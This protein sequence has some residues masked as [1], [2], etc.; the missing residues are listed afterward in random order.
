MKTG[1]EHRFAKDKDGNRVDA[2]KFDPLERRTRKCYCLSCGEVVHPVLGEKRRKHFRHEA[3]R[4]CNGE[5]YLHELGKRMLKKRWDESSSFVITFPQTKEKE[6]RQDC[7]LKSEDCR[8]FEYGNPQDLKKFYQTCTVEKIIKKGG[9][10]FR[11]DLL[12]EDKTGKYPPTMFEVCVTHPCPEEKQNSG[13]RIIEFTVKSEEEAFSL[14]ST[15]LSQ[16]E[17]INFYGIQKKNIFEFTD[18]VSRRIT[19]A[20]LHASGKIICQDDSCKS[21]TSTKVEGCALAFFYPSDIKKYSTDPARLL[22]A[23]KGFNIN[24]CEICSNLKEDA[25]GNSYC[26]IFNKRPFLEHAYFCSK[27]SP[28]FQFSIPVYYLESPSLRQNPELYKSVP[29]SPLS[30]PGFRYG[31]T[32]EKPVVE[33]KGYRFAK[34][35]DGKIVDAELFNPDE[36]RT[37]KC[38][39]LSCGEELIFYSSKTANSYFRHEADKECREETYLH[40]LG[41]ML[42]KMR[43]DNSS[44]FVIAFPQEKTKKCG[45]KCLLKHNDCSRT[46]S[47][48]RQN[49]KK[50]YQT[51]TVE[52]KYGDFQ[53][54][55]LLE[56]KTG[57]YPPTMLEV[58]VTHPCPE[59]KQNS[60]FRI[61]EFTMKSEEA[62]LFLYFEDLTRY[63]GINFYGITKATPAS[64]CYDLSK[65]IMRAAIYK[66][67]KIRWSIKDCKNLNLTNENEIAVA[68]FLYRANR[69]YPTNQ[70]RLF[71]AER[72]FNIKSCEICSKLKEDAG[73]DYFCCFFNKRPFQEH[74]YFCSQYSPNLVLLEELVD[75]YYLESP[76]LQQNPELYKSVP[77]TPR[78]DPGFRYEFI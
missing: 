46:E 55:L 41:K 33:E 18:D 7:P 45:F 73:G 64:L 35:A 57:K 75:E 48:N 13:F 30:D 17:G 10:E 29:P 12:L 42:L 40:E 74:A 70:A 5:T 9:R 47:V 21:I 27:Y 1:E 32:E 19:K 65:R 66:S 25:G 76:S 36:Q 39:C 31:L 3:D 63:K 62:A 8:R 72:G 6:C 52:K 56:D 20:E 16:K 26:G 15:D 58:C 14:Y 71:F 34:D 51:C 61:I 43:W 44:C 4:V 60:G 22:F 2:N 23:A 49:L 38:Y 28:N 54:D 11:A 77:P 37:R 59:E 69:I 24:S 53:A 68:F 78:S 67:G 50:F